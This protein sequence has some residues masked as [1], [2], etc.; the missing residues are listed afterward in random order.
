MMTLDDKARMEYAALMDHAREAERMTFI[1]WWT[2]G[3]AASALL[4]WGIGSRQ[5]GFMVPVVL[6]AAAGFLAMSRWREQAA[7][8][9]GYLETQHESP[10]E[11]PSF[12]TRLGRLQGTLGGRA[13]RD[14]HVTTFFNVIV[15][16][17]AVA[18]WMTA[19]SADHG[20][21]WAGVV[22]GCALAFASYAVS[23]TARMQQVDAASLWRRA[24]GQIQEVRRSAASR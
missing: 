10:D 12:H 5:P 20:E 4:A 11:T 21:L 17:A 1:S 6:V 22:T 13:A 18:A 24:D 8:I 15:V 2:A 23:E 3:I 14:W 9:A 16:T 7:L 19:S